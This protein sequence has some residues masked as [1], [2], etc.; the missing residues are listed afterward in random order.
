MNG[1]FF[2]L[3]LSTEE[4]SFYKTL[5][6][7]HS[8]Q[9]LQDKQSQHPQYQHSSADHCLTTPGLSWEIWCQERHPALFTTCRS[10]NE[11]QSLKDS[12]SG[13]CIWLS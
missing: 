1:T 4:N 11:T 12:Q 8:E 6:Q 2:T 7:F 9:Y 3:Y 10:P 13:D 5:K